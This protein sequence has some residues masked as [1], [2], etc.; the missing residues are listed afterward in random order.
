MTGL[1]TVTES[2]PGAA[3]RDT[4]DWHAIDWRRVT[5]NV[6]RLQVRI[7][8]ATQQGKWGKVKALQY[9]LTH[10]FSGKAL[11]VRRVTENQGKR[12]PGVDGITWDRPKEKAEVIGKLRHRGYHALPLRHVY[13]AKDNER[14][15]A[16]GIP[17]MYDRAMQALYRLARDPIAETTAD[18]NSYGF[19]TKR[20]PADAVEQCFTVLAKKHSPQWMLKGDIRAAFDQRSH[21]WW[22][23]HIPMERH[24]LSQWLK[25][26]YLERHRLYPTEAGTPQGGICSPVMLNRALDGL[27]A[28]LRTAFPRQVWNGQKQV[29][30]KVNLIRFADD[31]LVTGETKALLEQEGKP[32]IEAF[33]RERGLELSPEKT[34]VRSIEEGAD[35][36]GQNLRKYHG[37][38]LIK[39]ATK[40]IKAF[41]R[42]V[43]SVI[44]ANKSAAAGSLICLLNPLIRGWA[45]YH[46]Q[47]ISAKVFQSVDHAIFQAL[48]RWA[49]RRHSNKG[50]RWVRARYFTTVG[51]RHWV[52]SGAVRSPA[53]QR[54]AVRLYAAHSLPISRHTKIASGANPY[55]PRWDL[56]FAQRLAAKMAASLKGRRTLLYLWKRQGGRCPHCGDAI[57]P[58]TGWH[59]HHKVSQLRGGTDTV[60]NHVLLHPNC[61]MYVHHAWDSLCKPHSVTRVFE[62]ARAGYRA[63][64]TSGS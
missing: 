9:L 20:A 49:K 59:D 12:T 16:L 52:F 4:V 48:W 56:Y 15:R 44:K 19:R 5:H 43:R 28:R 3:S 38:L 18:P 47:V 32:V 7:V 22:L 50:V 57:T 63:T 58:V 21:E 45:L 24:L 64:D 30:P 60:D 8:K 10:S 29:C 23:A 37:K 34:V 62:K 53:G 33:L 41:L 14:R 42:K 61:H 2:G 26:G 46:R 25:A 11:A 6:R 17:T 13:I 39:P 40:S 55:H 54:Q 51:T 1:L 36:L 31:L 27:E 35:F